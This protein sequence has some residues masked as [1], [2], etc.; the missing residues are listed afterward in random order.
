MAGE[1]VDASIVFL[2]RL[3]TLVGSTGS[4]FTTLPL[5]VSQFSG[6]QF[7]V[8]RGPMSG[9]T[10]DLYL[11]ESLDAQNWVLG[12]STPTPFDFTSEMTKFFSYSFRLRW[13]R[14]RIH[15]TGIVTC[16]AEGLLRGGGAGA[17]PS[18]PPPGGAADTAERI[19]ATDSS[20]RALK[21]LQQISPSEFFTKSLMGGG[22]DPTAALAK[23]VG[24][25][26]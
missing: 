7:Q 26:P 5:D 14:L 17:W 4:V 12:P 18:A 19:P 10:F 1:T 22:F 9:G 25:G 11:E 3:T 16:W 15:A 8:W 21:S 13:F 6:V 24:G 20:R 2:P 23:A